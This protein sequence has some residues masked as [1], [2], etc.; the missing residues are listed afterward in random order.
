MIKNVYRPK[1]FKT[2]LVDRDGYSV[3]YKPNNLI[4]QNFASLNIIV[5]EE[6]SIDKI[7]EIMET[8]FEYWLLKF[9]VPLLA[10]AFDENG[11]AITIRAFALESVIT[12]YIDNEKTIKKWGCINNKEF[13]IEY[14]DDKVI[15]ECYRD[16]DYETINEKSEKIDKKLKERIRVTRVFNLVSLAYFIFA[17]AIALLG[18]SSPIVGF[19][20]CIYS[21]GMAYKNFM[22]SRGKRNESGRAKQVK[23][24]K[25]RHYYYHC[26]LNPKGFIK[27][28]ADNFKNNR[29]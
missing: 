17:V 20:A 28:K 23:E 15:Q 14:Y 11:N 18:F 16:L 29:C 6:L 12:G 21:I 4:K 2:I 25:M 7:Q 22:K 24:T 10:T 27:L 26:E 13:P 3:E 8:E 19:I 9:T 1:I 5:R